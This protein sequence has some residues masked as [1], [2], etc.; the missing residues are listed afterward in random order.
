[1]LMEVYFT[2]V[3]I[4][5]LLVKYEVKIGDYVFEEDVLGSIICIDL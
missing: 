2:V 4:S 5:F 3:L 1:M